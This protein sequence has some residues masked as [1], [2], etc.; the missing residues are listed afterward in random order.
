MNF[1]TKYHKLKKT[2]FINQKKKENMEHLCSEAMRG[3]CKPTCESKRIKFDS[4]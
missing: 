3:D 2:E 4:D 1:I